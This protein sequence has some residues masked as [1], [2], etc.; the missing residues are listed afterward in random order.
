MIK[1]SS[2]N[3]LLVYGANGYSAQLI[4]KELVSQNIE[5]VIAGRNENLIKAHAKKYD[6]DFRIFD[7]SL[8]DVVQNIVPV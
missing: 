3:K 7:F 8:V 6:L 5:P 1:Y 2:K 4:I